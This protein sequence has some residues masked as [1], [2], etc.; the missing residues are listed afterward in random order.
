MLSE[1]SPVGAPPDDPVPVTSAVPSRLRKL[2]P[3][4][5]CWP[6]I[7]RCQLESQT[8][9]DV[10]VRVQPVP[11][12]Q[13]YTPVTGL[14]A[15]I[16]TPD[17]RLPAPSLELTSFAGRLLPVASANSSEPTGSLSV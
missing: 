13:V 2:W 12:E 3:P 6:K 5:T 11:E 16:C 1:C 15:V 8:L 14:A 7:S 17:V 4:E 10:S 9:T